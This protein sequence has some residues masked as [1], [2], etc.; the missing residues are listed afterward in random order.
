[1]PVI[2]VFSALLYAVGAVLLAQLKMNFGVDIFSFYIILFPIGTF[3]Y[4]TISSKFFYTL[5]FKNQIPITKIYY[6]T[7]VSFI[8]LSY[9]GMKY[10]I[11]C[12]TFVDY[13]MD[14]NYIGDGVHISELYN[15]TTGNRINFKEYYFRLKSSGEMY[16]MIG[17][18]GFATKLNPMMNSLLELFN[19][20]ALA[21]SVTITYKRQK[22]N[23]KYCK[24]CNQYMLEKQVFIFDYGDNYSKCILE[25]IDESMGKEDRVDRLRQIINLNQKLRDTSNEFVVGN[26]NYCNECEQIYLVIIKYVIDEKGNERIDSIIKEYELDRTYFKLIIR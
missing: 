20:L 9:F 11:Y 18:N 8:L 3:L 4:G 7:T 24:K 14:I 26:F 19:I 13:S 22:P 6:F 15:E 23:F 1:M 17:G 10:Y 16:G 12:N 25:K 21:I 5:L 2:I